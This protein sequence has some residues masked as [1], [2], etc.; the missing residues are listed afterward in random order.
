M[1]EM[2]ALEQWARAIA[3]KPLR[4]EVTRR[5][6]CFVLLI[7]GVQGEFDCSDAVAKLLRTQNEGMHVE[8]VED[9]EAAVGVLLALHFLP[10]V[11]IAGLRPPKA[12]EKEGD[13]GNSQVGAGPPPRSVCCLL[14]PSKLSSPASLAVLFL[15]SNCFHDF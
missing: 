14:F 7:G 11:V 5:P 8:V 13:L 2:G 3:A 10:D 12:A 1:A 6:T 15:S 4:G 9:A